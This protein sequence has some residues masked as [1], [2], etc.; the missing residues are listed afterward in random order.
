MVIQDFTSKVVFL[1][2]APLIYFIEGNSV[3]QPLLLNL[4]R[5]ND[6]GNFTFITSTVT[7]LE[8]LVKPFREQ[9][10]SIA[11]QYKS[12]LLTSK[13]IELMEV[14]SGIAEQA[15]F[16]RAK[17]NLRTPD[18]IQLATSMECTADYFLTNDNDLKRISEISTV[19]LVDLRQ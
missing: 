18:A 16:L 7:L 13:G 19:T 17:Y 4:F 1:D 11:E 8:V 12:I 3:H 14:T 6:A 9:K 5:S 10:N 15:S 2:T